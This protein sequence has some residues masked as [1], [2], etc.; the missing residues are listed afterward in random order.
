MSRKRKCAPSPRPSRGEGWGGGLFYP[1]MVR[2]EVSSV[3]CPSPPARCARRPLP[4]Q[5]NGERLGSV[6]PLTS[7]HPIPPP[8][9]HTAP[10]TARPTPPPSPPPPPPPRPL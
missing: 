4:V 5:K 6:L 10:P 1:R 2:R 3:P 8:A 7:P 9:L